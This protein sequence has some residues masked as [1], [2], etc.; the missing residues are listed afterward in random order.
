MNLFRGD[1]GGQSDSDS[2]IDKAG[3]RSESEVDLTSDDELRRRRDALMLGRMHQSRISAVEIQEEGLD[4]NE[5]DRNTARRSKRELSYR[6]RQKQHHDAEL[7]SVLQ[8][9]DEE[10]IKELMSINN[11]SLFGDLVSDGSN[12]KLFAPFRDCTETQQDELLEEIVAN[13]RAKK[14]RRNNTRAVV[15]QNNGPDPAAM[16]KRI[17]KRI[18]TLLK[19]K[20][21]MDWPFVEDLEA[22]IDTMLRDDLG[23]LILSLETSYHRLIA[24]GV[25]QYYGLEFNSTENEEGEIVACTIDAKE[26][27]SRPSVK[28]LQYIQDISAV[29]QR[30]QMQ[31]R[32]DGEDDDVGGP[33]VM[34]KRKKKRNKK[35]ADPE[36][37]RRL[38]SLRVN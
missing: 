34:I 7:K 2:C 1:D 6:R 29:H 28:L 11:C 27:T 37:A 18:R 8:D 14:D 9:M 23:T 16:Y 32:E 13:A 3:R 21:A 5:M 19:R 20:G 25:A 24:R 10:E 4:T 36:L 38:A 30:M 12:L 31:D 15:A 26:G 33:P 35:K 17:D 22:E